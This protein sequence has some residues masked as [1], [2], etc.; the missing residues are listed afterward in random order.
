M[1]TGRESGRSGGRVENGC[2]PD[3]I[4]GI[5]QI[6]HVLILSIYFDILAHSWS[7]EAPLASHFQHSCVEVVGLKE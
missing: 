6:K 3:G 4:C 2:Y 7:I 5:G 1:G